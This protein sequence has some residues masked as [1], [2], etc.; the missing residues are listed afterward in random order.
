M[1][2]V[3]KEEI[4]SRECR[5]VTYC[6]PKDGGRGDLHVVKEILHLKDGTTTDALRFIKDFKRPFYIT[7]PGYRNHKDKKESEEIKKLQEFS[8]TQTDLIRSISFA[9]GD[10]GFQGPIRRRFR[11]PYIYGA[12]INSTAII[13]QG[14]RKR[15]PDINTPYSVCYAD[16][17]T[18][19]IDESGDIIISSLSWKNRVYTVVDKKFV[20]GYSNVIERLKALAIKLVGEVITKRNINWE[21]EIADDDSDIAIRTF[22]K[23]HEWGP[24]FLAIWNMDFDIP[25]YIAAIQKAGVDPADVLCD[26]SVPKEYRFYKYKQGPSQKVTAS[27]KA[28]PIKPAARWHTLYAPA[29]FYVIDGMCSYKQ[30]RTGQPECPS[31]ALDAIL[32]RE[33]VGINK[34]DIEEAKNY[35]GLAWH[36]F[37]QSRH[38]LEYV[39]YNGVDC[40][41]AEML[42]E[43]ITDLSIALPMLAG[44]SDFDNV[45]SQPRR[46]VD[47]LHFFMQEHGHIIGTTSDEMR[48]D[49]DD[50][51]VSLKD[52]IVML[53]AHLVADNGLQLIEEI[54][55][56][57]SNIR[58]DVGD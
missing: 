8:C 24:D 7:K 5:H 52:W 11:S 3:A 53:P 41:A 32:T 42:D 58:R 30:V 6:P 44:C 12:D 21:F 48:G 43:K 13:K 45:K 14:Y 25:K 36:K 23:A 29:K 33:K 55:H 51:T 2:N 57:R 19:V 17:E 27:G 38:P 31:Y 37:M 26:P 46:V 10:P 47:A 54:P 34:L 4:V 40:I 50:L 9:L 35:E 56:L 49:M 16:T 1:A 28:M 22:R 20:Q 15:W 39:I 18:N